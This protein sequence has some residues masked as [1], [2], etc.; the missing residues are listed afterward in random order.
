M[1]VTEDLYHNREYLYQ[2][3]FID[4]YHEDTNIENVNLLATMLTNEYKALLVM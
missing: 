3:V 2:M 1:I 4:I